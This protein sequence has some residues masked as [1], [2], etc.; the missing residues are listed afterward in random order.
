MFALSVLAAPAPAA[1]P[2]TAPPL[3][4]TLLDGTR[5]TLAEQGGKV[6]LINFWATWCAPCRKEMPA[7]D[8]FHRKYRERGL[9]LLAISLDEPAQ[10]S[11][12]REVMRSYSFPA[13][14]SAQARYSG[15][16]RIWR[17]PMTFVVDRQGRLRDDL[18]RDTLVVDEAFLEQRVA[19]LLAP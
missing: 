6:V 10:T 17:V 15:Y 4:A 16:G 14:L 9:V 5:F 12:V 19:P 7:L 1:E 13:A 8:A 18:L 2:R 11:A 3:S